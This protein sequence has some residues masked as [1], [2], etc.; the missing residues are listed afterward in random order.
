MTCREVASAQQPTATVA[1]SGNAADAADPDH[2]ALPNLFEHALGCDPHAP[3]ASSAP[4]C[5][6]AGGRLRITF[7]RNTAAADITL[8]VVAGDDVAGPRTEVARSTH[9]AAF[10][11]TVPGA[12]VNESGSGGRGDVEAI[13]IFLTTDPAHPRRFMRVVVQR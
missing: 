10:A 3:S 2:D 5:S 7:T 11:A 12:V 4:R 1:S 13:D 8:S 6:T 9:G